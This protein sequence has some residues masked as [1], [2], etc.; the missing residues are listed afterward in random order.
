[1][2]Q[3]KCRQTFF[4]ICDSL[5]TQKHNTHRKYQAA[6]HHNWDRSFPQKIL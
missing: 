2:S 4:E 5:I 1:M 3:V 6:L